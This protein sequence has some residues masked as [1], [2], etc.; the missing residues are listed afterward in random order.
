MTDDKKLY[1][2]REF[3]EFDYAKETDA[4]GAQKKS[5]YGNMLVKGILQRFD[6]LNQNGRI[7]PKEVLMPEIENYMKLVKERRATGEL[8]HDDSAVVNLKNVS[9]VITDIWV[10]GDVVWGRVEIL[11]AMNQGKQL[12]AL[13]DNG[14]KVGISSRAVGS[15]RQQGNANVVQ[16][17]LQLI[18]WDF[19]SE[20]STPNAFMMKEAK[21]LSAKDRKDLAEMLS[22]SDRIDRLANEI[23]GIKKL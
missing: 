20:P 23:L 14:I 13:F 12:K 15:V 6:T 9:H 16:D 2:L 17:D 19:V 22:K 10:E 18:C 11:E 7:Y 21:E 3:A 5:T 8:D 1:L 4:A